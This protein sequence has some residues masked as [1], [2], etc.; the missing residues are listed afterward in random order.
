MQIEAGLSLNLDPNILS[1][2]LPLIES[3]EV[4][5]IEWSF[6]AVDTIPPWYYDLMMSYADASRL[7][8]H[9]IYY[10]LLQ[11]KWT[12]QQAQWLDRLSQMSRMYKFDHVTE[13]FGF[14]TG[15]DFH[16]GAPLSVPYTLTYVKIAHDRIMRLSDACQC[17]IG[18][19]N[20][21]LAYN[22]DNVKRHGDFLFKIVS[23]VDGFIILDLHN[24]YCQVYNFGLSYET[25]LAAYPLDIVREIHISG[26]S[27]VSSSLDQSVS[28]R[29]D[30]HDDRVPDMVWD[31]L[32][33]VIP[34]C[35]ALRYVI[36]EQLGS[37]LSSPSA[38][39]LYH[40]D[41]KKL[42]NIVMSLPQ[43]TLQMQN[44]FGYLSRIIEQTPFEDQTEINLQ[45]QLS[46]ILETST[47]VQEVMSRLDA[48][49]LNDSSWNINSW[50]PY[51]IETAYEIARKWRFG[52]NHND[53]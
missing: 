30:T 15:E 4:D 36:L 23:A 11:S 51:M 49:Q 34:H 6:D 50:S 22:I 40:A 35:P 17:P 32:T 20:L 3:G 52:F 39:T 29:R 13:H 19:E 14:M 47:S 42:S 2:A 27:F 26:G 7:I 33:F 48:S 21:A 53:N 38:Q 28:I 31:M 24:V 10:S 18:I 37:G 1:T 43:K 5:V 12:P 46:T 45:S 44:K 8:G 9:G 16:K 41:F 25:L